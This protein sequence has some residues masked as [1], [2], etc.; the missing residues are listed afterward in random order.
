VDHDVEGYVPER[1]QELSRLVGDAIDDEDEDAADDAEAD[2]AE[3]LAQAEVEA[4]LAGVAS[5]EKV[6]VKTSSRKKK[7]AAA[8]E[9]EEERLKSMMTKKHKRMLLRINQREQAKDDKVQKLVEKRA[10]ADKAAAK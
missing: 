3:E 9:E 6:T 2:D 1:R 8:Q 10:K 4:E 7:A 5:S